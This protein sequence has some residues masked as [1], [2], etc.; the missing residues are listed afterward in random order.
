MATSVAPLATDPDL[1]QRIVE[2][3]RS[4]EQTIDEASKDTLLEAGYSVDAKDRAKQTVDS[5]FVRAGDVIQ[6]G[7]VL[8]GERLLLTVPAFAA[9]NL[10]LVGLWLSVVGMINVSTAR[11][12]AAPPPAPAPSL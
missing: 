11:K 1:R 5:F 10:V 6:A 9:I 8:I 3:K 2:V 4:Y 7:I 12:T